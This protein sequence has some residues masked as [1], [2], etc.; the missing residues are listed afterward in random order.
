MLKKLKNKFILINMLTVGIVLLII[1]LSITIITYRQK[2]SNAEMSVMD[3]IIF[4]PMNDKEPPK[5]PKEDIRR[6]GRAYTIQA[7]I[8][9]NGE[10]VTFANYLGGYDADE[11]VEL[12]K[13]LDSI[14]EDKGRA[15]G[16]IYAK[17]KTSMPDFEK[18]IV[19]APLSEINRET[20]G[21]FFIGL[22]IVLGSMCIFYFISRKLADVAIKPTEKAWK[23]QKRFI[24][25][26]SHDLKTPLT[27]IMANNDII[28]SHQN[29]TIA[30]QEKW[31]E[32]TKAECE[33]MQSL[34]NK[35]LELA[36]S[37]SLVSA[38]KLENTNISELTEKIALQ[39]EPVAY[40]GNVEIVSQITPNIIV[41]SNGEELTRLIYILVDNGIKYAKEGSKVTIS[42]SAN[43]KSVVLSVNNKGKVIP[44]EELSHIFDRFY[45]AD[46]AR[47]K[48]GFGL[49]LSIAKNIATAL[50][51]EISVTSNEENG[52]T[53]TFRL[54]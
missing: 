7:F 20:Q 40:E 19:I 33:H 30:D 46:S 26:V 6:I 15:L 37:E 3:K 38:I 22:S 42:L 41:K 31:L 29:S 11:F 52:T 32:S 53:F 5:N 4:Y 23:Q 39:L 54:K 21:A 24:A 50:N 2:I 49:G 14:S 12:I 47:A 45:R 25:D 27:V 48:G 17:Q 36:R 8:D 9:K 35:M 16:V 13:K 10:V 43:K 1:V 44:P 18:C 34:V 28:L 51:G